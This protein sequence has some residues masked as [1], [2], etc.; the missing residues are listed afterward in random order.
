M[1]GLYCTEASRVVPGTKVV[2]P[3]SSTSEKRCVN[4]LPSGVMRWSRNR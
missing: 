3:S 1:S 4:T 2:E